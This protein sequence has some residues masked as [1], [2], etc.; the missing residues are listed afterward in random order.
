VGASSVCH[1]SPLV[2]AAS[3][4]T[5]LKVR[6]PP[7]FSSEGAALAPLVETPFTAVRCLVELTGLQGSEYLLDVGC[8][9]GRIAVVARARAIGV[10]GE[11]LEPPGCLPTPF[12][13]AFHRVF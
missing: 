2:L 1:A 11:S 10:S 6:A 8:G 3:H 12:K 4:Y 7:Q 9:D 5:F 13:R